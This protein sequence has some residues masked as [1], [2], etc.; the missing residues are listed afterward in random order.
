MI[1]EYDYYELI[2]YK[3]YIRLESENYNRVFG[4]VN[5]KTVSLSRY[6]I[7]YEGKQMVDH[8]NNN[9]LDNRKCNLRI[10]DVIGNNQNR[11]KSTAANLTSIYIGVYKKKNK[12][13]ASIT[14]NGTY[15]YLGRFIIE[16][17]AAIARDTR[18]NILNTNHNCYYKLNFPV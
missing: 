17:E 4:T 8:I 5:N 7:K 9:T 2:K 14:Y 16:K 1:D 18:A 6:V 12:W 10:L 15:E 13:V 3:W 11:T